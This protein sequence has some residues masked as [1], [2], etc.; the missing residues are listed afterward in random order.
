[1]RSASSPASSATPGLKMPCRARPSRTGV[2][3]WPGMSPGMEM[4]ARET[5][6]QSGH[7]NMWEIACL[8]VTAA[9]RPKTACPLQQTL[10][11]AARQLAPFLHPSLTPAFGRLEPLPRALLLHHGAQVRIIPAGRL[12]IVV[13]NNSGVGVHSECEAG[14]LDLVS[15]MLSKRG[16]IRSGAATQQPARYERPT[17]HTGACSHPGQLSRH[18]L[19]CSRRTPPPPAGCCA[20]SAES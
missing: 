8:L 6:R 13:G 10:S 4:S 14:T 19:P 7:V 17:N 20:R 15:S 2:A 16:C 12:E 9:A 18:P 3:I 1:M 5:G 11:T